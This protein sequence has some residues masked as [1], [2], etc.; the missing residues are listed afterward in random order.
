M[1]F[2]T[3]TAQKYFAKLLINK[4]FGSQIRVFVVNPGTP[5]AKCGVSYCSPDTI[6]KTDKK[7]KFDKIEIYVDKI[8]KSYLQDAEIDLLIDKLGFQ[9]IFKAPNAKIPQLSNEATLFD[10][11]EYML[12]S[13][14]NPLLANHGGHVKLIKITDNMLAILQ[15]KGRC[16]GCSMVNY[17][18]TEGIEKKILKKFPE[19]KGVIDATKSQIENNYYS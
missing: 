15:F 11:V 5:N 2:I 19:L 1:I 14:I 4:K 17:T 10:R 6:K 3:D 8:S 16:N 12:Q 18:L 13:Q 7:I 9:L